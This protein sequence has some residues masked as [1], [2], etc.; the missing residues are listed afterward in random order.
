MVMDRGVK[1]LS[2]HVD[3]V[4]RGYLIFGEPKAVSGGE[5]RGL[6][7]LRTI[8]PGISSKEYGWNG[9]KTYCHL[10]GAQGYG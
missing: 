4:W 3:V 1:A 7:N 6:G 5:E 8:T 9:A 2:S 10:H